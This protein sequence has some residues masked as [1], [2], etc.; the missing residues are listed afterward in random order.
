ML[1]RVSVPLLDGGEYEWHFLRPAACLCTLWQGNEEFGDFLALHTACETPDGCFLGAF[2]Q[3]LLS[4]VA[5]GYSALFA[6]MLREFFEKSFLNFPTG[7]SGT[8]PCP[9]C[10]NV[11]GHMA[12]SKLEDDE[13]LVHYTRRF[14]NRFRPHTSQSFQLMRNRLEAVRDRKKDLKDRGQL[15]GLTSDGKGVPWHPTLRSIV[16]PIQNTM[17]ELLQHNMDLKD[18]DA[19]A[20][21]V[22]LPKSRP[23]LPA[24]FFQER[25]C[26]EEGSHMRCFAS[27]VLQ[28]TMVL[29]LLV[30]TRLQRGGTC[31]AHCEAVMVLS[32]IFDILT[33]QAIA[34]YNTLVWTLYEFCKRPKFHC[35]YHLPDGIAQHKC[36][37]SCFAAERKHRVVKTL[38][39]HVANNSQM[40]QHLA[41]RVGDQ[42]L[43]AFVGENL[44]TMWRVARRLQAPSCMVHIGDVVHVPELDQVGGIEAFLEAV[45]MNGSSLLASNDFSWTDSMRAVA[46]AK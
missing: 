6:K 35:H 14:P 40:A 34:R 39:A 44:P 43:E 41:L 8:K 2:P 37:L 7:A 17:M 45:L 18:I 23:K 22:I 28:L 16:D 19:F 15:Y 32:E 42:M 36:C 33:E 21:V 38:A 10:S 25:V 5:G 1:D 27:E 26:K 4:N 13:E 12:A 9:F 29:K 30:E 24:N 31:P 46:N 20:A 11:I 3:K